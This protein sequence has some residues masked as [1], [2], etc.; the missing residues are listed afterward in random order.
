MP[1]VQSQAHDLQTVSILAVLIAI[2]CVVYWRVLLRLA[3]VAVAAFAI[4]GLILIIELLR[5][6]RL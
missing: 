1:A 2:F 6:A 3:A 4:G 5:H